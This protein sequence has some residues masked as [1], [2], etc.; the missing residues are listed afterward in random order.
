MAKVLRVGA[1]EH[2]RARNGMSGLKVTGPPV[3]SCFLSREVNGLKSLPSPSHMCRIPNRLFFISV[4][5][6]KE[7]FYPKPR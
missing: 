5:N 6:F 3:S 4:M 2:K 1:G 7:P